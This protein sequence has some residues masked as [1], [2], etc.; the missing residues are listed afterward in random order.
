M[1]E[2]L[3]TLVFASAFALMLH[4]ARS[5]G[6][7]RLAVVAMLGIVLAV[8]TLT[9]GQMFILLPVTAL[10]WLLLGVPIRRAAFAAC[11]VLVVSVSVLGAWT[12][13]NAVMMD[14]PIVLATDSGYALRI[15]HAAYSTG[16]YVIADDLWTD[17]RGKAFP[18][19]ELFFNDEG[20]RRATEYASSH[21]ARELELTGRKIV[22]LWRPDTDALDWATTFGETPVADGA[23]TPLRWLLAGS[24]FVLLG[25]AGVG[26]ATAQRPTS[27]LIVA[28]VAGWTAMHVVFFGE[29]RYHV[30]I[31]AVLV[32]A[33]SSGMLWLVARATA[34]A[35]PRVLAS[36]TVQGRGQG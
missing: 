9:R 8:G 36:S 12:V 13:R 17:S 25:F 24:Y 1:P 20:R 32:P 2:T 11:V 4:S 23:E 6:S 15:G 10:W 30:P 18:E 16:R 27:V 22:W 29:P 26:L 34:P 33:A 5:D 21:P 3:F 31:L 28:V 7:V 35:R 19:R 14:E